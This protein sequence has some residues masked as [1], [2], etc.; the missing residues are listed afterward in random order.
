VLNILESPRLSPTETQ[1]LLAE[2]QALAQLV[3]ELTAR[4]GPQPVGGIDP[5][6]PAGLLA[7]ALW[8]VIGRR[9]ALWVRTRISQKAEAEDGRRARGR[10]RDRVRS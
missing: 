5:T 7:D 8:E 10:G 6:L 4:A 9:K 1:A 3:R 2:V